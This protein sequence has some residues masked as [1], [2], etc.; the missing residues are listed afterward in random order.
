V[1]AARHD[2]RLASLVAGALGHLVHETDGALVNPAEVLFT[3]DYRYRL[4]LART[5]GPQAPMVCVM[6]NP[7]TASAVEDDPTIRRVQRFARREGCGGG[8]V[9]VN[10]FAFRSTDPRALDSCPDPVGA[11]NDA[12]IAAVLA[13]NPAGPVVAAWGRTRWPEHPGERVGW[14]PSSTR[15]GSIWSALAATQM[16]HRSIRCT[17]TAAPSLTLTWSA[18]ALPRRIPHSHQPGA[19]LRAQHRLL[20]ARH[21]VEQ[22]GD[23]SRSADRREPDEDGWANTR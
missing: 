9:V 12:V 7:S 20:A 3:P 16:A 18:T 22:P 4:A 19:D 8:I 13:A 15:P 14:P 23:P 10:L 11:D 6:L 1:T 5:W 17:F 2:I 21:G